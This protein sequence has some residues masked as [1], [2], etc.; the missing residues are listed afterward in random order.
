MLPVWVLCEATVPDLRACLVDF[1]DSSEKCIWCAHEKPGSSFSKREV[2]S[3]FEARNK[4]D[5]LFNDLID[6]FE[7]KG[8][9]WV[10]SGNTLG[11]SFLWK[12]WDVLWYIDTV[13]ANSLIQIPEIFNSFSGYNTSELNKHWKRKVVSM[14]YDI[15][16]SHVGLLKEC[17]ITSWMQQDRWHALHKRSLMS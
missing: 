14:S 13:L 1:D 12:L 11:K 17:L 2:T 15:L 5:K 8:W 16:I 10:D 7:E 9:T 3:K 4:K 6:L